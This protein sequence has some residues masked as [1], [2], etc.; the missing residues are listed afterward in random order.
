MGVEPGSPAAAVG[1]MPFDLQAGVVGDIIIAVNRKPV[2]NVLQLSKALEEIGVGGTANL[3]VMRGDD[4]RELPV[5][6]VDL[7]TR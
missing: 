6:I 2:A 7:E 5:N 1:L 3:L 4:T